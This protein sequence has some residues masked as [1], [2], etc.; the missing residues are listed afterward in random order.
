[1]KSHKKPTYHPQLHIDTL[2][3]LDNELLLECCQAH[4]QGAAGIR[5]SLVNQLMDGREYLVAAHCSNVG[6]LGD[7]LGHVI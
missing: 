1:M 2:L 5:K 6:P 4:P 7:C 3:E